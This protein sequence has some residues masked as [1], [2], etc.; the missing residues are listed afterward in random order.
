MHRDLH[1]CVVPYIDPKILTNSKNQAKLDE[2]SDVYSVYV[3]LWKISSGTY[4][5]YEETNNIGLIY[6][7]TQGQRESIVPNNP[8]NYANI[9]TGK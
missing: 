9:Y 1:S 4:H 7:I 3:L 8:N 6:E 5:F 2:K